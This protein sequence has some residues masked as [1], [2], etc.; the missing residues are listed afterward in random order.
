MKKKGT[1]LLIIF[2]STLVFG[3]KSY[4][5]NNYYGSMQLA[6]SA[7][8]ESFKGAGMTMSIGKRYKGLDANLSFCFYG[9]LWK[10]NF[11][12]W[13]QFDEYDDFYT[14]SYSLDEKNRCLDV[15][16]KAGIGYDLLHPVKL[17]KDSHH[18][19]PYFTLGYAQ[20]IE[21]TSTIDSKISDGLYQTVL[22]NRSISGVETSLG[23]RY[24]YDF[25]KKISIGTFYEVYLFVQ[26]KDV[27][28]ISMKYSF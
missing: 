24:E 20:R 5:Q 2:L 23:C 27:V 19:I 1:W 25:T 7:T 28:G 13:I 4:C 8:T 21:S 3:N 6:T 26:D 11:Y 15:V 18:F 9:R 16:I 12:Q 17:K 22:T 10:D 14:P